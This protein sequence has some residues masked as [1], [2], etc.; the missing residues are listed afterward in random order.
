MGRDLRKKQ[1]SLADAIQGA[2]NSIQILT[3]YQHVKLRGPTDDKAYDTIFDSI[4]GY[5]DTS[6]NNCTVDERAL[7]MY[8]ILMFSCELVKPVHIHYSSKL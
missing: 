4:E 2:S 8:C 5:L 6:E 7:D 3:S 1:S